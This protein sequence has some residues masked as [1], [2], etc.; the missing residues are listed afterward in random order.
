MWN[1]R[2]RQAL[3]D[4]V[5]RRL[6]C[7]TGAEEGISLDRLSAHVWS[8]DRARFERY[9]CQAGDLRPMTPIE[10]RVGTPGDY[11]NLIRTVNLASQSSADAPVLLLASTLMHV[12]DTHR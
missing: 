6:F 2:R 1:A 12:F 11:R 7:L 3:L 8:P 10:L 5:A 9:L 4:D